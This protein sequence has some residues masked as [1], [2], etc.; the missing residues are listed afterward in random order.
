MKTRTTLLT[1]SRLA[2]V[3]RLAAT[4]TL[5]LIGLLAP[6]TVQ[7]QTCQSVLQGHFDWAFG[8]PDGPGDYYLEFA[9]VSNQNGL[10]AT[11]V[12]GT[13]KAKI[14]LLGSL[15]AGEGT[16]YFSQAR[17]D[18]PGNAVPPFI[19][20]GV[21]PFSPD[22]ADSV[23]VALNAGTSRATLWLGKVTY[24][25]DLNCDHAGV[26]YGVGNAKSPL[27]LTTPMFVISLK[28]A[29]GAVVNPPE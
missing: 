18:W 27:N 20:L 13:L 1:N 21:Y 9:M 14:T 24:N 29:G 17:W 3:G 7:A 15:F 26:L 16:R 10:N 22:A 4:L 28:R 8:E 12:E 25:F 2:G 6:T 19:D 23:K 11:F 5:A